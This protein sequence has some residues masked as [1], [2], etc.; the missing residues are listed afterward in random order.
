MIQRLDGFEFLEFKWSQIGKYLKN[1]IQFLMILM[2]LLTITNVVV[3]QSEFVKDWWRKRLFGFLPKRYKVILNGFNPQFSECRNRANTGNLNLISVE[4]AVKVNEYT[5]NIFR[6]YD[7]VL[8]DRNRSEILKVYGVLEGEISETFT[9]I[10]FMGRVER[11]DVVNLYQ[12][13]RPVF[14][15][16]EQEA[17]CPNSL[18]EAIGAGV[19]A[20]GSDDGAFLEIVASAGIAYKSCDVQNNYMSL[21]TKLF[22]I[23]A[24]IDENY[25]KL[26]GKALER[27][28]Y[29]TLERMML[30][31]IEL[32]ED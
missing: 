23:L 4:G 15:L 5:Q 20:I 26:N 12:V 10:E 8:R 25:D 2:T 22:E 14:L 1:R 29:L 31:Y 17:A 9:H 19:P 13:G 16:L 32:L 7:A 27:A 3:F 6:A 28:D 11:N 30:L 18:I 21:Q 24:N